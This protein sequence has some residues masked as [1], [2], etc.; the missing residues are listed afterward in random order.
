MKTKKIC[1]SKLVIIRT[2]KFI[3]S[4]LIFLN[5]EFPAN[6][7]IW[8]L[9][10]CI[11]TAQVNNKNLQISRN[12]IYAVDQKNEEAKANLFPKIYSNIDYK[13]YADLPTQLMPLSVFGGPE[14]QFKEAQFGV[15]HNILANIQ[16]NVPVYNSQIYG[17]IKTT[18]IASELTELQYQKTEE[19]IFFEIS[20]LYYNAQI[21]QKQKSFIENNIENTKLL[22]SNMQLLNSQ[23]LVRNTD[24]TKIQLQLNQLLTQIELIKN[25]YEQTMNALKFTMG[26]SINQIVE[27]ENEIE[28]KE[29]IEY[30]TKILTDIKIAETQN[31]LFNSELNTLKLSR[32][33][34]LSLY[35]SYGQTGYGFDE[36]PNNF[37]NF[38]PISFVGAQLSI[39]IFNGTVTNKKIN[40]KKIEIINSEIQID[41][42]SDQNIMLTDNANKKRIIAGKTIENTNSQ[43]ELAQT[44]YNQ[45]VLQQKEGTANLTDVLL[46]DNALRESQQNY[47]SAVIDYLKADLE[48]KKLTGNISI[49]SEE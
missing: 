21:L 26:I 30:E 47:I 44:I 34:S 17:A 33:P 20:N 18:K 16:I 6:A 29:N 24:V 41:L 9:Q 23:L 5:I 11:D 37:L 8:N 31:K 42:I 25:N 32:L 45:T 10:Q 12:N 36:K 3:F 22:L 15:P 13:Y 46:A 43:I 27:I 35:G 38:Y 1:L 28:Y 40:Q 49:K 48:L 39:P 19:Q 4:I 14:G 2:L 7:Q